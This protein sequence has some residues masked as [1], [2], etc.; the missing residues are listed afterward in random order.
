M[1]SFKIHEITSLNTETTHKECKETMK[2][3]DQ[4]SK[5]HLEMLTVLKVRNPCL[6]KK[7]HPLK[8]ID[9]KIT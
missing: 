4:Q 7:A 6:N 1:F 3:R 9:Y 2:A 5:Y 8:T